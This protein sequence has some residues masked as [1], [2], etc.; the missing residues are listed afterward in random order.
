M[1]N[2]YVLTKVKLALA[3]MYAEDTP[4]KDLKLNIMLNDKHIPEK[5]LENLISNLVETE[6]NVLKRE[7]LSIISKKLKK[8]NFTGGTNAEKT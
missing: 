6:I 1:E 4:V 2:I 5:V 8:F 7:L 3:N